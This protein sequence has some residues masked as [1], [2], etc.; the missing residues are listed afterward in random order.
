VLRKLEIGLLLALGAVATA[1]L[2]AAMAR[3]GWPFEL[4]SH[5]RAQ[6]AA[7]A[8]LLS[9][10]LAW[11]GRGAAAVL[12]I[13]LA[14][15]QAAPGIQRALAGSPAARCVG[16]TV[17]IVTANL[18]YS[19]GERDRFLEWL[20]HQA[21]DVVI[22]QEVT[23]AWSAA[24]TRSSGYPYRRL[25]T[26]EDPYGIGVLSRRPLQRVEPVDLAAD[27]LPSLDVTVVIDGRPLRVLG[28]HT[29]WPVLPGLA[30]DR[31]RALQGA[32]ELA[33][34]SREPVVLVGDL[35]LTPYSPVYR[36]L[37]ASSGLRDAVDDR[38]WRPTWLA[39]FWPLALR[40]DH[41]LVSQGL[42]VDDA[43]I[44]PAVGSDHRPVVARLRLGSAGMTSAT[45]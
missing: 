20:E 44:G 29:H 22:V 39:G 12:A 6:Y 18:Q 37:L 28:L 23:E 32:A 2:L 16:P 8:L 34:S 26:R 19:N 4:F 43:E 13:A 35:N 9:G 31:D 27:G 10:M 5:F 24:L 3:L 14:S 1:A 42:C 30:R 25:L 7:L 36:R 21:A 40:I 11:R 33:R 38:R 15:W 45:P 17:E 41:V